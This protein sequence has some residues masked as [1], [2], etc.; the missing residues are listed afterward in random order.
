MHTIAQTKKIALKVDVLGQKHPTIRYYH[1]VNGRYQITPKTVHFEKAVLKKIHPFILIQ[2][3]EF[4]HDSINY[5]QANSLRYYVNPKEL[6]YID[7]QLSTDTSKLELL[8]SIKRSSQQIRG[9]EYQVLVKNYFNP[10]FISRFEVTNRDYREFVH[11]VQDS[12]FREAI[13]SSEYISDEEA[14]EMLTIPKDILKNGIRNGEFDLETLPITSQ[15]REVNR[16]LYPFNW[17]YNY[18]KELRDDQI[19][20]AVFDLYQRPNERFYKKRE[21]DK[22][23]LKYRYST[24]EMSGNLQNTIN[25][26]QEKEK[27]LSQFLVDRTLSIYPDT[28]TWAKNVVGF[29]EHPMLNMY[30][31]HPAY[32]DHP[33]VGVSY[34][35]AKAYCHWKQKQL[36]KEHPEIAQLFYVDIP[37]TQEYEW[38]VSEARNELTKTIIQDNELITNLILGLENEPRVAHH[39]LYQYLEKGFTEK[40]FAPGGQDIIKHQ[41]SKARKTRQRIKKGIKTLTYK[42]YLALQNEQNRLPNGI[43]YLSNNVSEWLNETYSE[44]YA[45]LIEAYINYNCYANPAYCEAQRKIDQNL[46]RQNDSTGQLIMGA[47]WYDERFGTQAGVN[48]AGIYPKTF[49]APSK[50]FATVGFR[51]VLRHSSVSHSN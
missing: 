49:R 30:F 37:N 23:H 36:E 24:L 31:W 14:V 7:W 21:V 8:D 42:E 2:P 47:N 28:S 1:P 27:T 35:Q 17:E 13:Y 50:S 46:L 33:V 40:V 32:D 20:P 11:W 15:T 51:L 26:S 48:T 41:K 44:N 4:L 10:F 9:K 16:A 3:A 43:E 25:N 38:A 29:E 39:T 19:I 34:E 18:R 6:V 12:I 5:I 22:R 45:Q